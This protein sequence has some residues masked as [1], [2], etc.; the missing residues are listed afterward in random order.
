MIQKTRNLLATAMYTLKVV[1]D[2]LD[3]K[4]IIINGEQVFKYSNN[5][6]GNP[7]PASITL[8]ATKFN[9]SKNGKWQYKNTDGEWVDWLSG[10]SVITNTTLR[11]EPSSGILSS[12]KSMQIRY[13]VDNIYDEITIVKVSD[14]ANGTSATAYW[15]ISSASAIGKNTS[16][17][18]NPASITFTSKSQTGAN[19]VTNYSGRFIISETTD[20]TAF[21]DKYTSSANESTKT[22]TPSATNIKSIRVRLYKAGGTSVLLDEQIIP[23]VTDGIN[24]TSAVTAVLSNDSHSIPCNTSGTPSTYAGAVTTMSVFVGSTDTSSSWTYKATPTNVTGTSSNSNRTFTVTGISADTG[25]VDITASRSGYSSVTKRFTVVKSKQGATGGPGKDAYTVVLSNES[26]TFPGSTSAALAGNATCTI[27][28][29]KG[30]TKVNATIGTITGMPTGMSVSLSNNGTQN[31]SFTVS[32]TTSMTTKN[33]TL[34]V[35]ITVDGVVFNKTFSYSIALKGNTGATGP[36]GPQGNT[37][38]Q[39]PQGEAKDYYD[40]SFMDGK[41]Y[42]STKYDSYIEPGSN[43]AITKEPTSKIGGNV[44]QIQNDTWLYSKNKIAIEQNKIYKFTFRVRQ[45]QDPLNGSDKNKIYAGATTFDANGNRL[46]PNNG[47]Y[48]IASSQ[49]ITVANGWKEYT[50]YMSTSAKNALIGTDGKTLCPAVKAFDSGT[51]AIK[52]MFIVNYSG[53]NGIAQ[54]DYLTM[55]DYTQEW[56]ALNI[57]KDKLNVDSQEVFDALTDNGRIQGIYMEKGQLYMSMDN[58]SMP[59]T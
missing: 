41:K 24:G 35:P 19:A 25:Y 31:A 58:I 50:A 5:F 32:V 15:L 14:G 48:F 46:S 8:T 38:P 12:S 22:Y 51:V 56:N 37:G 36:Q 4:Y 44:L 33:G 43:V 1:E 53:G 2:G 20:G 16:N 11:V 49:G 29:Y 27:I 10:G 45:I 52:P 6:S 7:T 42:W 47:T 17:A 3:A 55:E 59:R 9:I 13:I 57:A 26:H 40:A 18:F 28:A 34:T 21:T 54:V 23:V 30:A 39:G